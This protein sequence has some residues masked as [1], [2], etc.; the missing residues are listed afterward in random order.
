[1]KASTQIV[2]AVA[3][4]LLVVQGTC[5][6]IVLYP[7]TNRFALDANAKVCMSVEGT[8]IT[9]SS[10]ADVEKNFQ[11]CTFINSAIVIATDYMGSF[12]LPG[13]TDFFGA[14]T[15]ASPPET[16]GLTSINLPDATF[17]EII[18]LQ[19]VPA[20][21]SI[22]LP[23]AVRVGKLSLLGNSS[24]SIDCGSMV[25]AGSITIEGIAVK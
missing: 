9:V 17:V 5:K 24:V 7:K 6:F 22:Y 8:S 23:N 11:N 4:A 10:Q 3:A 19:N 13:V 2:A 16:P 1:M 21:T 12:S 14:I 15:Q 20:L 18:D 25:S